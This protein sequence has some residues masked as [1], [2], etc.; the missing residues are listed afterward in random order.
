MHHAEYL[1]VYSVAI[2]ECRQHFEGMPTSSQPAS[3]QLVKYMPYDH[4]CMY[5]IHIHI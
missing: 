2:N 1:T 3:F 5:D 4:I